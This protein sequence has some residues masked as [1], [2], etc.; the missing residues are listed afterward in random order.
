MASDPAL[1]GFALPALRTALEA[2]AVV[3]WVHFSATH[4]HSPPPSHRPRRRIPN[5]QFCSCARRAPS[6]SCVSGHLERRRPD[7]RQQQMEESHMPSPVIDGIARDLGAVTTRRSM[8]R[9][10]GGAAA[11]SAVAVIARGEAAEAKRKGR[12]NG[13]RKK[14]KTQQNQ[15][16]C[17]P[18]SQVG[19]VSVPGTGASVST[20]VL[21]QGQR[22]RL[23][24]S[25]FWSSN[26]THGQDAFADF[27]FAN[28]ARRCHDLRGGPPRALH[29]WG[30]CRRLGQLHH[31]SRLRAGDRGA[32]GGALLA[33]LGQGPHRQQWLRP[34]RGPLRLTPLPYSSS[35]PLSPIH[36]ERGSPN[37]LKGASH[38]QLL[39]DRDRSGVP[40]YE[41]QRAVAA[42][43]GP[44]WSARELRGR[45]GRTGR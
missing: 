29:R 11:M 24:A 25:G 22:Y 38:A 27:E 28:P 36:R 42:G 4:T 1:S 44:R 45:P 16:T 9:L 39:H 12:K 2:R 43:R 21:A 6:L 34:R 33:L 13:K 32:G 31:R 19:A 14:Q 7:E 8:V 37:P 15:Q 23:R 35:L 26:A 5:A 40:G 10:L 20:P 41:W 18:G 3:A 17:T 30:Q